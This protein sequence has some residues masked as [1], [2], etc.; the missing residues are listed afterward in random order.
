MAT[1]LGVRCWK[2]RIALVAVDEDT[3]GPQCVLRRRTKVP[4]GL[5]EGRRADWF[6]KITTEAIEECHPVGVAVRISDAGDDRV[7]SENDGAVLVAAAHANLP[8]ITLGWQKMR[9]PL[10]VSKEAGAWKAFPKTDPFISG[11]IGDERDVAMAALAS[12]RR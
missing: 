1:W 5:D 3:R 11:L 7:R 2:D 6:H 8:S 4:T 10:G 12:V 9:A